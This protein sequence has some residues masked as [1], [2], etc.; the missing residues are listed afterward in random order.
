MDQTHQ[1]D[2]KTVM[3]YVRNARAIRLSAAKLGL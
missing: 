3:R 2:V 1:A